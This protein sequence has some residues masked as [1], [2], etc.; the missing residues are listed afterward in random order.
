[1]KI[2]PQ[3]PFGVGLCLMSLM[4]VHGQ[5]NAVE[6]VTSSGS[7]LRQNPM[8]SG[9]GPSSSRSSQDVSVEQAPQLPQGAADELQFTVNA[10]EVS[11]PLSDD[12]RARIEAMTAPLRGRL[13]TMSQLQALRG[14]M[15]L[16]LFRL[17]DNL[18]SVQLPPQTIVDG[19]VRFDATRGHIEQVLV[20]NASDVSTQVIERMLVADHTS[21]RAIERGVR[22]LRALP[23]VAG[24]RALL[25]EGKYPGGTIVTVQVAAAPTLSGGV[26][27]DNYGSAN[28]GARRLGLYGTYN[29]PLGLG[30]RLDVLVYAT[31]GIVQPDD[32]RGGQTRL[33][34]IAY[35]VPLGRN[36]SRVGAVY[37]NVGYRLG[38][39]FDGL[40]KGDAQVG[41][42]YAR[43]PAMQT[44]STDL[45]IGVTLE[46]KNLRDTWFGDLLESR[47]R[48]TSVEV[49]VDGNSTRALQDRGVALSYGVGVRAGR[50]DITEIDRSWT[51]AQED[52]LQRPFVVANASMDAIGQITPY[53]RVSGRLRGQ[54]ANHSLDGSERLSLGGPD[55]V[56]AYD[57]NTAAVDSG[58]IV[59]LAAHYGVRQIPGSSLELF[60]D[61][62]SGRMHGRDH[63]DAS[64]TL[65]GAGI[66][67]SWGYRK[68]Q[69]QLAYSRPIGGSQGGQTWF[70]V[71]QQF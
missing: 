38:G 68:F 31:P 71:R 43:V 12:E 35:E 70:L 34:R 23:G 11:G 10:F 15:A 19:V 51:Q 16:A 54:W 32:E 4:L 8:L 66:G 33:A 5:A 53:F 50:T 17:G 13:F 44:R 57:Q 40:S 67:V 7:L 29:N 41:A 52:E 24:V 49:R 18:V 14:E 6:S 2:F 64:T 21:L 42:L 20:E 62:G 59:S 55:A 30:D 1:M 63:D 45:D 39:E 27:A 25:S 37:S 22:R 3:R 58:G 60:Y 47:R 48:G 56:R 28:A 26:L 69:A 36:G 9:H 61:M 46:R 65:Q